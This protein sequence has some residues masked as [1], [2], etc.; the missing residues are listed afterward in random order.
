MAS[1]FLGINAMT[2]P[3]HQSQ[4][5]FAIGMIIVL[6]FMNLWTVKSQRLGDTTPKKSDQS[7]VLKVAPY[8][9]ADPDKYN[10]RIISLSGGRVL[11]NVE[12]E[13]YLVNDRNEV[14]WHTPKA[15]LVLELIAD[16]RGRVFGIGSDMAQFE[17]DLN[18]GKILYFGK[19]RPTSGRNYFSQI[20]AYKEGQY[21][22][23]ESLHEYRLSRIPGAPKDFDYDYVT[24]WQG[25]R[26]LW[27]EKIPEDA[28]L[29]VSG[30]KIIAVTKIADGVRL[31]EIK[32]P[33]AAPSNRR[34]ERTRR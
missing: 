6:L 34:L 32:V 18:T 33:S 9:V 19:P 23:V 3:S 11:I 5:Y 2:S 4:K 15:E 10:T 21:L 27:E 8:S 12:D 30:N 28:E 17:V 14:L 26:L 31:Q 1:Q 22:V 20:K 25:Q 24:C 13:L 7:L 16:S 29:V